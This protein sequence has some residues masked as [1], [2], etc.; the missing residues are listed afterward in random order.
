V[1]AFACVYSMGARCVHVSSACVLRM[2]LCVDGLCI[3]VCDDALYELCAYAYSVH[4]WCKHVCVAC[5]NV[6]V[7]HICLWVRIVVCMCM[8]F[9]CV[10]D[11]AK[12][13]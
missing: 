3:S 1:Y 6:W 7:L 13:S 5:V 8:R 10:F 12:C 2:S 9:V 11:V 4:V